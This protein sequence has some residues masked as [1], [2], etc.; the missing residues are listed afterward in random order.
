MWRKKYLKLKID[1]EIF[2]EKRNLKMKRSK[3]SFNTFEIMFV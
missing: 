2:S 3:H 1:D